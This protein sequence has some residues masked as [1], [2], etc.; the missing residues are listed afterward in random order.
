[1]L[2]LTFTNSHMGLEFP[3]SH[4]EGAQKNDEQGDEIQSEIEKKG[5]EQNEKLIRALQAVFER[6]ANITTGAAWRFA[7]FSQKDAVTRDFRQALSMDSD[8]VIVMNGNAEAMGLSVHVSMGTGE[9]RRLVYSFRV[10]SEGNSRF[11]RDFERHP[12][13]AN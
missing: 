4:F 10:H 1:M 5:K 8:P 12:S 13:P 6:Y 3:Q 2:I 11:V 9:N 7:E